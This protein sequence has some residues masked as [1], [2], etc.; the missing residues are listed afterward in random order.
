MWN[1][2]RITKQSVDTEGAACF[3]SVLHLAVFEASSGEG[4]AGEVS[5]P[6]ILS[7]G[8]DSFC[9]RL[10]LDGACGESLSCSQ[11]ISVFRPR[12]QKHQ[13]GGHMSMI[14]RR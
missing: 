10:I 12:A 13:G 9:P 6:I 1:A 5:G 7:P 4:D 14:D 2:P 3:F 8:L 11:L